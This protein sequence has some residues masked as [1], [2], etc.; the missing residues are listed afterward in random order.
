M[1]FPYKKVL[2]IG[3]TSGIGEA[4]AAKLVDNGH[5]VVVVG[6]RK[7]KLDAFVSKHG[8]DKAEAAVFDITK[9]DQIPQ[10]ATDITKRHPDLDCVLLNSGI[11]RGFDFSKP[12]T[13]NLDTINEEFN[14]NYISFIHL[15]VAF[16]P[17]LQKL[18]KETSLIYTTSGLALVPMLRCA[19]Y[20]ASKAAL[21][22]FILVLREQMKTGPGN[23]K[24]IE[25]FPP[26]VQT[27]LHD[28]KHQP[29]IKNGAKIGMPL[30]QFVEETW[31]GLDK[32]EDQIPIGMSKMAFE[33]FELD[34][35][36]AFHKAIEHMAEMMKQFS[37]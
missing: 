24:V 30:E 15:T 4:L 9:L 26:A 13:I 16:L 32:G 10:F 37:Q 14:T 22:H 27:E 21:H 18:Q 29:D 34:R 12:E 17:H 28:A 36:K 33:G 31:A 11:Q 6:R 35:Q 2:V 8:S 7:E 3:A 5:K 20:C 23:V 1:P 25:I 19:N